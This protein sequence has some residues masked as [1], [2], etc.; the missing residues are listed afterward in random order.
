[1]EEGRPDAV[2]LIPHGASPQ[3][4]VA[5]A[6]GAEKLTH[7]NKAVTFAAF[8]SGVDVEERDRMMRETP[9]NHSLF[10]DIYGQDEEIHG[11][12]RRHLRI[13]PWCASRAVMPLPSARGR[14]SE[15]K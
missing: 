15:T 10:M 13:S 7:E 14:S 5:L 1:L 3:V 12:K 8:A 2:Y 4:D 11:R 6:I 9:G